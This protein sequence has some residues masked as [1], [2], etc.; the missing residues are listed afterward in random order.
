MAGPIFLSATR[1]E[2]RTAGVRVVGATVLR[3]I[4]IADARLR[5]HHARKW[6]QVMKV[7]WY[8]HRNG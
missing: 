4:G 5:N 1:T 2:T 8:Y 6:S 7:D 3:S